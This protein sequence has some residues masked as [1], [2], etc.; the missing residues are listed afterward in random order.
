MAAFAA[1]AL[2]ASTPIV[3][4]GKDDRNSGQRTAASG[5]KQGANRRS[6]VSRHQE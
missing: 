1:I 4:L 2:N 5:Q 3:V 6:L